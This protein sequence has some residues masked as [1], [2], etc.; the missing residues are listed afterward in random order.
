MVLSCGCHQGHASYCFTNT[1]HT[2]WPHT[3]WNFCY[4]RVIFK[5]YQLSSS[6]LK[7]RLF[8]RTDGWGANKL[9]NEQCTFFADWVLAHLHEL[10]PSG[11]R[12]THPL[13]CEAAP[14]SL[15]LPLISGFDDMDFAAILILY[16][17]TVRNSLFM[18]QTE[19]L[20][21]FQWQFELFLAPQDKFWFFIKTKSISII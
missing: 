13:I 12:I 19:S 6:S 7:A 14:F 1:V 10:V 9:F 5:L 15:C 2:G 21:W 20:F 17:F 18:S 4:P 8:G 11:F 16:R 3:I